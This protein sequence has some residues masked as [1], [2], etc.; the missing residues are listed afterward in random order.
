MTGPSTTSAGGTRV[1]LPAPGA[2]TTTAARAR[3]TSPTIAGT[4]GSIGSG[5]VTAPEQVPRPVPL[6]GCSGVGRYADTDWTA[7]ACAAEAAV[8]AG[9]LGKVLLVVVLGVVELWSG[10]NFCGDCPVAGR[11][12]TFLVCVPGTLG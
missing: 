2:A 11:S 12:Q 3:R 1:V 9:V 8:P 7:H 4:Y 10:A 6:A 5:V